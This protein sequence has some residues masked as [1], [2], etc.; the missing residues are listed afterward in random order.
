MIYGIGTD[1]L[2]IKKLCPVFEQSDYLKDSF[3]KKTYTPAEIAL[4]ESRPVPLYCYA[5]RFAG[6]EAVFKAL[7]I[8][9]A[10][11]RLNEIEI[12]SDDTGKPF[13]NLYG[14]AAALAAKKEISKILISLSFEDAY[15]IGYA[16]ATTY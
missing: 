12:L 10:D 2:E 16:A 1:I 15:A 7:T 11:I 14:N 5:T 9:G 8:T 6:K 3:V 4:A 13:V